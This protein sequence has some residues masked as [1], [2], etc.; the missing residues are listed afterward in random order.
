M[1]EST[2]KNPLITVI[3]PAHNVEAFVGETIESVLAQTATDFEMIIV[4]DGSRDRTVEVVDRFA[5]RDGRIV[6]IQTANRGVSSARNTAMSRAR[7]QYFA[8]LDADDIWH[9]T[10]LAE[11]LAIL[12]EQSEFSHSGAG[13]LPPFPNSRSTF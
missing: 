2:P 10:L 7:G 6:L 8:L 9:P 4:D 13:R 3:T 5:K 12:E 11:Q 1:I